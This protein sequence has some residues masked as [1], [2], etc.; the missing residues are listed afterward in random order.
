MIKSCVCVCCG[1]VAPTC[2]GRKTRLHIC[3]GAMFSMRVFKGVIHDSAQ[4]CVLLIHAMWSCTMFL[5]G[6]GSRAL[7]PSL[8]HSPLPP[9]LSPP[10]LLPSPLLPSLSPSLPPSPLCSGAGGVKEEQPLKH[11]RCWLRRHWP[12]SGEKGAGSSQDRSGTGAP[13]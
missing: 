5:H 7:S 3:A 9:S 13:V 6:V 1:G 2:L 4:A 8:L 10:S 11:R 12:C